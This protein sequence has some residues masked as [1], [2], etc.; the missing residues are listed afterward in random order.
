MFMFVCLF[1]CCCS[2]SAPF[3]SFSLWL[4]QQPL[5]ITS[6]NPPTF[7]QSI[8]HPLTT[9]DMSPLLTRLLFTR[10]FEDERAILAH[11]KPGEGLTYEMVSE[12]MEL[13]FTVWY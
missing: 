7:E 9:T 6:L 2:C 12:L 13:Q 4:F 1:V 3:A 11:F 8:L 5:G 10:R